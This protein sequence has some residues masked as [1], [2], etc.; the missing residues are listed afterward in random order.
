MILKYAITI[1]RGTPMAHQPGVYLVQLLPDQSSV[2]QTR[3]HDKRLFHITIF[4]QIKK[5]VFHVFLFDRLFDLVY[6]F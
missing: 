2:I 4:Y 3:A 1:V 6:F 5:G